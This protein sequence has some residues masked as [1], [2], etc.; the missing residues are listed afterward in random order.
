[1]HWRAVSFRR[2][3]PAGYNLIEIEGEPDDWRCTLVVRGWR[4]DGIVE[5]GRQILIG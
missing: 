1:L 4:D 5:V 3:E 2:T